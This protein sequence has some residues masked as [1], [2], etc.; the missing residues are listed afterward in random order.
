VNASGLATADEVALALSA[1]S[2]HTRR[3]RTQGWYRVGPTAEAFSN[4]LPIPLFNGVLAPRGGVEAADP[5]EVARALDEVKAE[6][7]PYS[8]RC[9]PSA[10][11]VLE[12]LALEHGLTLESE[13]PVMVLDALEALA[14]TPAAPE[15]E[16][17][18]VTG[19]DYETLLHAGA[20]AFEAT[21]EEAAIVI[22]RTRL[23]DPAQRYWVGL[24]EGVPAL[25]GCGVVVG[26][27]VGIFNVGT[28]PAYRRRG[29]GAAITA[30][31]LR[32]G[33][34]AGARH[35]VL[36]SSPMGFGVYAGLGFRVVERWPYWVS[37]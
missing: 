5:V 27:W 11:D 35:G 29:Y 6:G 4:G 34:A 15:L 20:T 25:I 30:Q 26:E 16:I 9:R 24:V 10:R 7:L 17:R 33:L 23:D 31:A 22:P 3:T 1:I 12:P 19:P 37:T 32:D 21:Y 28:A 18:R 8:L 14:P 2:E 36:T 13:E